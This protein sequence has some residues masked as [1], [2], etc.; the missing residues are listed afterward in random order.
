MKKHT[1][2]RTLSIMLAALVLITSFGLTSAVYAEEADGKVVE[3]GRGTLTA[4]GDG[5]AIMA[6]GRGIVE[7]SGNGVLWIKGD[8]NIQITGHGELI[9]FPDGWTQYAG[10]YGD[11]TIEGERF[12]VILAGVNIDLFAEGRGRAFL[13][14]HGSYQI[15]GQTADW[16]SGKLRGARIKLAAPSD[17]SLSK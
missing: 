9:E 15:N 2:K 16:E 13:W 12:A 10:F 5:I 8:A 17:V 4:Q 7:V 6:V 14:G 3:K 1:L 11:A